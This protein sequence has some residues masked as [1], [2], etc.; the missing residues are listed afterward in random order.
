MPKLTASDPLGWCC[1]QAQP[2]RADQGYDQDGKT[3]VLHLGTWPQTLK[4]Q[5]PS[6]RPLRGRHRQA[7]QPF[8]PALR[9][10]LAGPG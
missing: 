8:S 10:D 2:R 6:G 3:E 5:S 7:R 9:A 1:K 4:H